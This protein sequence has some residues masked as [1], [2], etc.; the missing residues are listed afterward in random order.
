MII[1][2]T[3][4]SEGKGRRTIQYPDEQIEGTTRDG[5]VSGVDVLLCLYASRLWTSADGG[6][7]R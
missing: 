6:G 4:K 3:V 5:P 1:D 2:W 7:P